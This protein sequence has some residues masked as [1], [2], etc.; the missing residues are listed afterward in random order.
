MG[1]TV[2][3][4]DE[5]AGVGGDGIGEVCVGEGS[6]GETVGTAVFAGGNC[7]TSTVLVGSVVSVGGCELTFV[8]V[9]TEVI[10][11]VGVLSCVGTAVRAVEDQTESSE[12]QATTDRT[13]KRNRNPT[14]MRPARI[15]RKQ[16]F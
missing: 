12:L 9:D 14:A 6:V 16:L 15:R 11:I 10:K 1:V 4:L 8:G 7:L 5:A 3:A 2:E 13:S